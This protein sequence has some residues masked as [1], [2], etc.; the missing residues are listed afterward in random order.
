MN[1]TVGLLTTRSAAMAPTARPETRTPSPYAERIDQIRAARTC[2]GGEE[3]HQERK[4]GRIARHQRVV[5]CRPVAERREAPVHVRPRHRGDEILVHAQIAGAPQP[6]LAD[7][8]V[9]VRAAGRPRA[10]READA[11]HRRRRKRHHHRQQAIGQTGDARDQRVLF[12]RRPQPEAQ[13]GTEHR[14]E[15]RA[16]C[17][18]GRQANAV[19]PDVEAPGRDQHDAE[20]GCGDGERVQDAG[21]GTAPVLVQ[22]CHT[23][24][25]GRPEPCFEQL[26]PPQPLGAARS[27]F[28]RLPLLLVGFED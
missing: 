26:A 15:D 22:S 1:S 19:D 24:S 6:R 12:R 10:V 20:E 2:H 3:R 5:R 17:A 28:G 4:A 13:H 14:E 11:E 23:E 25:D 27:R 9:G 16:Q 18:V 7:V 8:A 21:S